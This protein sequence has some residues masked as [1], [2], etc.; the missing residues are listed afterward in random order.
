VPDADPPFSTSRL[1]RIGD[2]LRRAKAAGLSFTPADLAA[3][4]DY[5]AW[6][7]PTL[8]EARARITELFHEQPWISAEFVA[9]TGR[10]LKT[11]D[12]IIAKLVRERTRLSLMQDIAGARIVVASPHLQEEALQAFLRLFA[13]D[14][15]RVTK[16]TR[17]EADRYGYRAVHLV[18]RLGGRLAEIQLRTVRQDGWAQLVERVDAMLGSD[19]KHG[20]GPAEW[21]EWLHAVSDAFHAADRGQFT[22]IPPSPFEIDIP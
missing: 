11:T 19:L 21:L 22:P 9:V 1:N 10:P 12:A 6:H 20:R 3:L 18:V 15:P 7:R 13:N 14:E 5:R 17:E 8:T 2:R 16:D 4:D